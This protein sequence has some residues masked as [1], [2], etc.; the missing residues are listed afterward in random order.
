MKIQNIKRINKGDNIR[1]NQVMANFFLHFS[2]LRSVTRLQSV[3]RLRSVTGLLLHFS[4]LRFEIW[5]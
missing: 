4:D 3:T 2:L 1:N 5:I